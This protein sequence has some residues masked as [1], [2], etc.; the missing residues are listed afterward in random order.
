MHDITNNYTH[1]LQIYFRSMNEPQDFRIRK[2]E[3]TRF[4]NNLD[5]FRRDRSVA[6]FFI[7]NTTEGKYVG[8]NI[9]QIQAIHLL[10]EPS[11]FPEEEKYY[12][13]PIKIFLVDR[14]SP[15]LTDTEDPDKL[16]DL[17]CDL[18]HGPEVVGSFV[19]FLDEDG[20]ELFINME[21]ILYIECPTSLA[22]EGCEMVKVRNGLKG[23]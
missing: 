13:G 19:S 8:I 17:Y 18:E 16:Y 11:A 12:D 1:I 3:S 23:D 10:W 21:E 15:I 6:H 22:N 4:R 7:C 9:S 20:E 5:S 14:E 2:K